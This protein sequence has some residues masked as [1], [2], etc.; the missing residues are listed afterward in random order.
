MRLLFAVNSLPGIFSFAYSV[1]TVKFEFKL[2]RCRKKNI[3]IKYLQRR[4]FDKKNATND[5]NVMR[6]VA[7][8]GS[9]KSLC[10]TAVDLFRRKMG[11]YFLPTPLV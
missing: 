9:N 3:I 2:R 5:E 11:L 6:N 10:L 1:F 7:G 8:V 4:K